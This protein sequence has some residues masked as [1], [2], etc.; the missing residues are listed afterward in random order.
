MLKP[1]HDYVLLEKEKVEK[2]NKFRNYS[3][4]W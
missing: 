3:D 1:L 4:K 2:N